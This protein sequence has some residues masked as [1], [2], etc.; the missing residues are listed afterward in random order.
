[1]R[2]YPPLQMSDL[3]LPIALCYFLDRVVRY[4]YYNAYYI[5]RRDG[6]QSIPF[7]L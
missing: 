7:I 5:D 3:F 6:I 1:M 2:K 4:V